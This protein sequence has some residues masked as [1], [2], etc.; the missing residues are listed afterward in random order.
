MAKK[1]AKMK[2]APVV[3]VGKH[4]AASLAAA[5][6][7]K[8][9]LDV[10]QVATSKS[11]VSDRLVTLNPALFELAGIAMPDAAEPFDTVQFLGQD[12]KVAQTTPAFAEDALPVVGSLRDVAQIAAEVADEAGV[13]RMIGQLEVGLPD[14]DSGIEVRVGARTIDAGLVLASDDLP[15]DVAAAL[16]VAAAAQEA[17]QTHERLD[18]VC[19]EDAPL[20]A[21]LDLDDAG[22]WGLL[23]RTESQTQMT[24]FAPAGGSASAMQAW[25]NRLGMPLP[26]SLPEPEPVALA[27]ALERDVVGRLTL[28]LGPAGGFVSSTGE[29]VYP[30]CHS[31]TYAAA[32]AEKA[33]KATHVQD[34]LAD[35]RSAWGGTLGEYLQGPQQNM[36]FLL[37]LIYKNPVMTD[38]LA[39]ALFRGRSLVR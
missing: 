13:Q 14:D 39:D 25:A 8:R 17:R 33:L 22:S 29:E 24:V 36:R 35:Y 21:A 16:G 2:L 38:R 27:G 18:V 9:G 26:R 19:P 34:A 12:D 5:T 6:L 3:V 20:S 30:C 10:V 28:L 4:P 37:P 1:A 32:V 11:A 23:L 7:A 15:D 31:A